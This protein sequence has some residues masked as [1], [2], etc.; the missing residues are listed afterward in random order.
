M[1]KSFYELTQAGETVNRSARLTG[2][3]WEGATTAGDTCTVQVDGS[4]FWRGRTDA[5]QT[6]LGISFGVV[7]LYVNQVVLN[8]ISSGTLWIYYG[9]AL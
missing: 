6:Y 3:V 9:D 4:L 8:Q 2:L 7:G 1:D 5:T